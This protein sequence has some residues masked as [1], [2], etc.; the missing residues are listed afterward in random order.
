[1]LAAQKPLQQASIAIRKVFARPE[2]LCAYD[3]K[4]SF[5]RGHV[6]TVST[7][8]TLFKKGLNGF[9]S[10]GTDLKLSRRF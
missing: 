6:R 1:M 4:L 10:F 7:L 9:D 3:K 2:S 5:Q 8:F